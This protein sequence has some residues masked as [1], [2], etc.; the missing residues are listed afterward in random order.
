MWIVISTLVNMYYGLCVVITSKIEF[1]CSSLNG[2][3]SGSV[4]LICM[5]DFCYRYACLLLLSPLMCQSKAPNNMKKR[6]NKERSHQMDRIQYKTHQKSIVVSS[7]TDESHQLIDPVQ[8]WPVAQALFTFIVMFTHSYNLWKRSLH[9]IWAE[10]CKIMFT[11]CWGSQWS[12]HNLSCVWSIYFES[13][14]YL[15]TDMLK[16]L[17]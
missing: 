11:I 17:P 9:W 8:M 2:C 7:Q 12:K 14:T 16:K 4:I 6:D 13:A 5:L 3:K 15:W 1:S 10:Q